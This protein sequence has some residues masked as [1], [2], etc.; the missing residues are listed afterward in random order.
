MPTVPSLCKS[1]GG[2]IFEIFHMS[3]PTTTRAY[4]SE[5]VLSKSGSVIY[6]PPLKLP[7]RFKHTMRDLFGHCRCGNG[8]VIDGVY[9]YR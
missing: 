9:S 3:V 7:V 5:T 6:W 1:P 8:D 2:G 4:G